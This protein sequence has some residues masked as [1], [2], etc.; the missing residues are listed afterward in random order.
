MATVASANMHS[1]RLWLGVRYRAHPMDYLLAFRIHPKRFSLVLA[2]EI[3]ALALQLPT[4][5]PASIASS[6]FEALAFLPKLK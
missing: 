1:A 2:Q 3:R 4:D 5:F 6:L